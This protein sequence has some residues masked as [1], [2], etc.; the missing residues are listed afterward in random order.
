MISAF[1]DTNVLL[2]ITETDLLLSLSETVGMLRPY[3]SEYVFDE[4]KEHLPERLEE[5]GSENA[6]RKACRR[7]GHEVRLSGKHGSCIEMGIVFLNCG[8]IRQRPRRYAN[9]GGSDCLQCGLPRDRQSQGFRH[10]RHSETVWNFD[11]IY[12]YV[13]ANRFSLSSNGFLGFGGEDGQ[14]TQQTPT[15]PGGA[16]QYPQGPWKNRDSLR[17]GGR[18]QKKTNNLAAPSVTTPRTGLLRSFHGH[19]GRRL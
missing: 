8:K 19:T 16:F 14:E 9:P 13:P 12:G 2:G 11:N 15:D 18:S 5:S 1:L 3:W 7:I 4:L 6:F 17:H 10:Q